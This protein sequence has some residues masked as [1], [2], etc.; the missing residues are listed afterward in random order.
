L[1]TFPLVGTLVTKLGLSRF[2]TFF[3][4]QYRAGIPIVQVL[5]ECQGVTG[6][7]RLGLCVRRIR[8]GVEGGERL[9]V[10][11]ASV[12]YFPQLVVRML[13]IG[14]EAGNLE[15]TLGKVSQ[16]IRR[17][18]QGQHQAVLPAPGADHDRRTGRSGRF[19]GCFHPAADIH[20]DWKHQCANPLNLPFPSSKWLLS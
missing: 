16:Y 7:A 14:E 18:G 3:A 8:E 13:S 17:G 5:R 20:D 11:A 6:N 2:A 9:A 4:S 12:G 15:Q 1:L 19:C 10:M